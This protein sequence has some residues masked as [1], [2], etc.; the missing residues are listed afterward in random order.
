MKENLDK[1]S[2]E[3]KSNKVIFTAVNSPK[4]LL[5]TLEMES[6]D[7]LY[8]ELDTL[9]QYLL[10]NEL[11]IYPIVVY[12]DQGEIT[13]V[14]VQSPASPNTLQQLEEKLNNFNINQITSI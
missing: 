7:I 4:M 3:Q 6:L 9:N 13:S 11:C 12:L 8:C 10:P 2:D 5:R 1:F 14:A